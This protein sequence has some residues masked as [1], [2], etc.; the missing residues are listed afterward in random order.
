MFGCQVQALLGAPSKGHP[1]WVV[2]VSFGFYTCIPRHVETCAH[3][4]VCPP[5]TSVPLASQARCLLACG[6]DRGY[7]SLWNMTEMLRNSMVCPVS[8]AL[9]ASLVHPQDSIC[10]AFF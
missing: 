10:L 7:V 2:F 9:L 8:G 6:D 1:F 5:G 4:P 3:T